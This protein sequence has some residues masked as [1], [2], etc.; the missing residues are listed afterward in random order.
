[1]DDKIKIGIFGDSF[2]S[3]RFEQE[4]PSLDWVS[5]LSKEY[6]VV[7]FA[8]PGT[9]IYY[10]VKLFLKNF[11]K[12]DKVIFVVTH[13]S[14]LTLPERSFLLDAKENIVECLTPRSAQDLLNTCSQEDNRRILKSVIDYYTY[15]EDNE[16]TEY[17]AN[18]MIDHVKSLHDSLLLVYYTDLMKVHEKEN[19]FFKL[20]NSFY[21][22]YDDVRNCHL[23]IDNN[24]I[25]FEKINDWIMSDKFKFNLD[26]FVNPI[27]TFSLYFR[28]KKC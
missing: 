26:D 15:L 14:R 17:I 8:N 23:T 5:Y 16:F 28:N 25:L 12:F 7:N 21:N 3:L 20:S 19:N 22:S 6:E 13:P 18:L 4:N 10:S 2:A 24:K 27:D 1:M 9:S 11:T